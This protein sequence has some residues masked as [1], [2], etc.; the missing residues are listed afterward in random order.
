MEDNG[1]AN[2]QAG[3]HPFGLHHDA[4]G[5]LVLTD[6]DGRQHAGVEVVRAFPISDPRHGVALCDSKGKELLWLADLEALPP[7]LARVIQDE[8]A[9]REFV[10]IVRRILKVSAPVEPSEWEVETD[11][12]R[13]SFVLNSED[14]VHE[15]DAHRA[16]ITDAHGIRYLIPDIEQ[17]DATSRRLLERYL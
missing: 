15:L 8:L 3:P 1:T 4:W 10:P 6:A 11:R 9:K 14:D 16:L 13:T 5:R 17:L 7:P 2:G 12:G